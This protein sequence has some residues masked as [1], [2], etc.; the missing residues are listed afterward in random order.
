MRHIEQHEISTV[1]YHFGFDSLSNGQLQQDANSNYSKY[2]LYTEV[3]VLYVRGW[4]G[5]VLCKLHPTI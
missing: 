1:H 4:F 5:L 3:L 2:G